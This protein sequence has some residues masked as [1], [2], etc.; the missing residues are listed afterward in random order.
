V[1]EATVLGAL[2]YSTRIWLKLER[3]N[4]LGITASDVT[5][6]IRQQNVQASAGEIDAPPIDPRTAAAA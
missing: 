2:D 1:G 6:A 4:A 3:M 5:S